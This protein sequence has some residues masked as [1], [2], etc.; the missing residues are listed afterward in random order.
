MIYDYNIS[1]FCRSIENLYV[2]V[3]LVD[4]TNEFESDFVL[5]V[6]CKVSQKEYT[7]FYYFDVS[8]EN[9]ILFDSGVYK[10]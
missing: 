6:N 4:R 5:E 3:F 1:L 9:K 2:F 10:L 7:F 8:L